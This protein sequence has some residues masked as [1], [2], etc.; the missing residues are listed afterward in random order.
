MTDKAQYILYSIL[1]FGLTFGGTA[2]VIVYNYITPTNPLGYKLTL[3]GIILLIALV[4]TA[5]AIFEKHYR[6]KYDTMLQQLAE[7]TDPAVK[8]EISDKIN[9]H[10]IKNNVYQRI[11]LL[12]PF[13]VLYLCTWLG[14]TAFENLQASVGLILVS[15]GVGSVFNVIKKPV[16][17]RMNLA[18]TTAKAQSKA[19]EQNK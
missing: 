14:A 12:L 18:K 11:M 5:K 6:E 9:E 3:G 1:D 7:A 17:E 4:L 13:M 8:Q 15:M 19:Q 10:K 16:R 2:G